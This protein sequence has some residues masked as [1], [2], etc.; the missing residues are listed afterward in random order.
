MLFLLSNTYASSNCTG[1]IWTVL[2]KWQPNHYYS[3]SYYEV[4]TLWAHSHSFLS[5]SEKQ[6]VSKQIIRKQ[7]INNVVCVS[8]AKQVGM[9][10]IIQAVLK[11]DQS[12][13][14]TVFRKADC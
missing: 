12:Q 10:K 14:Q 13:P 1:S 5:S 7:A 8:Q 4:P 2:A 9:M 11:I 6:C 3:G